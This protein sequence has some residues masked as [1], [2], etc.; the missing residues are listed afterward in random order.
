MVAKRRIWELQHYTISRILGMVYYGDRLKALY[1][2]LKLEA[3]DATTY[4]LHQH[5]TQLCRAQS[6]HARRVEQLLEKLFA[7]YKKHVGLLS[8]EEL[9]DIIESG[10]NKQ[11]IPLAALIWFA[12][13]NG[14]GN[15]IES[16]IARV[17]HLR[18]HRALRLYDELARMLDGEPESVTETLRAALET[19]EKLRYRCARLERKREELIAERDALKADKTSLILELESQKRMNER[20]EPLDGNSQE[21]VESMRIEL[22]V[23]REEL[24]RLRRES[25]KSEPVRQNR[26]EPRS[27]TKPADEDMRCNYELK[28]LRVAYIGGVESLKLNYRA[29]VESFGCMFCYH[30]GHCMRGR[31]EIEEIVEKSDIIVCP[32]DINS[33]NACRMIKEACKARNKPCYFLRSSGLSALRKVLASFNRGYGM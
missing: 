5:L 33:H 2:D 24:K 17:L 13:R 25:Q 14:N 15:G 1:K 23:L 16:R 20:L 7:P 31:K 12:V 11:N 4:E 27:S 19:N 32:V 30:C 10:D 21:L 9:C 6:R 26:L 22:S 18:E 28:G 8:A 29:V 3:G